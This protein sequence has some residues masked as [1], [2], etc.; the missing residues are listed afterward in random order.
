MTR[1]VSAALF[2]VLCGGASAAAVSRQSTQRTETVMLTL[3][4]RAGE[5]DD[6]AK[7]L[8]DHWSTAR[9]LDLVTPDLHVSLRARDDAGRSYF[10]EIFTWRDADVPDNAPAAIRTIWDRLNAL[11]EARGGRPGL[12]IKPVTLIAP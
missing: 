10:V 8:A 12:D 2:V 4:P 1:V 7:A 3:Q 6:L 9:R 5:E 11:T